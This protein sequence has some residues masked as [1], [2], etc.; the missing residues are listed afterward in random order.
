[1]AHRRDVRKDRGRAE[2]VERRCRRGGDG[3]G[4]AVPVR[5]GPHGALLAGHAEPDRAWA[6]L[7]AKACRKAA[8]A[9]S[10]ATHARRLPRRRRRNRRH[11][12]A[13]ARSPVRPARGRGAEGLALQHAFKMPLARAGQ[14]FRQFGDLARSRR[15]A[16]DAPAFGEQHRVVPARAELDQRGQPVRRP[17]RSLTSPPRPPLRGHGCRRSRRPERPAKATSSAAAA[18]AAGVQPWLWP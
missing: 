5:H 7:A 2:I 4:P 16:G 11:S 12:A 17:C 10:S 13:D 8:S 14:G 1:M 15:R 18:A 9:A 6:R 3:R